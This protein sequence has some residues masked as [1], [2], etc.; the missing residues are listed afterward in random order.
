MSI[1]ARPI[2]L[3][4]SHDVLSTMPMHHYA[5]VLHVLICKGTVSRASMHHVYA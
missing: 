2:S 1:W 5:C 3:T 4:L